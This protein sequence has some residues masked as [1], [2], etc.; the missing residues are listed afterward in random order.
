MQDW[1]YGLLFGSI[2][3]GVIMFIIQKKLSNVSSLLEDKKKDE[4]NFNI[5]IIQS[6][7]ALGENNKA[8][9]EALKT[10][11][12]NGNLDKA[13]VSYEKVEEKL[14]NYLIEKASRD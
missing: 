9:F 12:T 13:M 10:G 11:R 8:M 6:L 1:A 4:Q 7:L 5:I 3:P 14:N 2:V